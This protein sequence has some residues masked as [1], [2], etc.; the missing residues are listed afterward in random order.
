MCYYVI[1]SV[2]AFMVLRFE[3]GL[4]FLEGVDFANGG[5]IHIAVNWRIVTYSLGWKHIFVVW[6]GG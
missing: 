1:V 2:Y 5:A 3:I 6:Y 4:G